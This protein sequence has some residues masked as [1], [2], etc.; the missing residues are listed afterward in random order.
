MDLERKQCR[1]NES[2]TM[3]EQRTNTVELKRLW[4]SFDWTKESK[5]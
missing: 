1:M 4:E 5:K 3:E 2:L